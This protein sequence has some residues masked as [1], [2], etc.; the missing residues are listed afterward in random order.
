M[1]IKSL[2]E[3]K[4]V[5]LIWGKEELL[6]SQGVRRLR[7]R[8]AEVADLDF[9]FDSFDGEV[10]EAS[11][12]VA[13]ANTLPFASER[14][15]I[16]VKNVDKMAPSAQAE[17]AAYALD[18]APTACLVLVATSIS[19]TGKLFKAV[20]ALGG[21]AEYRAPRK[22]DYPS[23]VIGHFTAKGRQ[24]TPDGAEAL[25]RAVGRDLRRIDI[26]AEK[27]IAYAGDKTRIEREDVEAVVSETAP[28][29]V[30]EFL[31]ALGARESA[32]ALRLL[33]DLVDSGESLM[34]IHSMAVR[35]MRSLLSV[36][37]LIDRDVTERQIASEIRAADWQVRNL[38]RQSRR[39][40]ESELIDA[41]RAAADT[42]AAMKTGAQDPRVAFERWIIATC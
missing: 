3:L 30:F 35:H 14:R 32:T 20:D 16:V 13:A 33:A 6:L 8:V 26:E 18:P 7:D 29:S 12:V 41:L 40:E 10:V 34:G 21:A 9:N 42:E 5:Y 36:R 24:L 1:A 27:I 23:W 11:A 28:T 17:L 39:F 19:R 31:D 15:L 2:A 4:P 22:N 25:V 37:A 38:A